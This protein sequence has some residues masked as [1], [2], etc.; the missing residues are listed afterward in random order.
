MDRRFRTA[1]CLVEGEA[2]L[3]IEGKRDGGTEEDSVG[4]IGMKL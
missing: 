2:K 3:L 1:N 4:R